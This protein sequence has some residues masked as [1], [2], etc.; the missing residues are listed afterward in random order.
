MVYGR[1]GRGNGRFGRGGRGRGGRFGTK[2][3]GSGSQNKKDTSKVKFAPQS[4]GS[5]TTASYNTVR[6]AI[7][8]QIQKSYKDGTDVV[9]SIKDRK[10]VDLS[11]D[12]PELM[13]SQE[14]NA[15]KKEISQAGLNIKYQKELRCFMERKNALQE[16]LSKA[17][18]LIFN[19]YC[20]RSMQS[21][22][23]EHPEFETKIE[24]NPIEL[25]EA[26]KAL[27][28]DTVR[29]VYPMVSMTDAFARLINSNNK[30]TSIYLTM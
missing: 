24:N 9:K 4:Q 27:M 11:L 5:R 13:E 20:T 15:A 23:E 22:V 18:A 6:D 3:Q 12:K 19:N 25:L 8:S 17:Y 28:H 29:A 2:S 7:I 10:V 30:M 21:R 26:I 1:G 16:G 14:A